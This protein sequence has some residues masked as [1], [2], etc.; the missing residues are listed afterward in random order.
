[1]SINSIP[2]SIQKRKITQNYPNT[3]MFAAMG[4]FGLGL[5]NEIEI[6]VV[7]VPSVFEPLMKFYCILLFIKYFTGKKIDN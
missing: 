3:I 1:M 2:L 6:A 7:N 5:K 4:F